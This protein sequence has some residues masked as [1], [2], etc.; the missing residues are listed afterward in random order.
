MKENA[1]IFT[2]ILHSCFDNSIYQSEFPSILKLAN[3]TPVFKKSDRNSTENYR[4]VSIL[5]NISKIFE[6]C[7]LRQT[8]SFMDSYLTKQQC[9]FRKG[10]SPQH[11]LLVMLEK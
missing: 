5:S 3:I 6:Q 1:D 8:S 2:D 9:G 10:Y 7:M 11:R 4:P